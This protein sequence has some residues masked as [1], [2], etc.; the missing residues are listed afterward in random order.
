MELRTQPGPILCLLCSIS[1]HFLSENVNFQSNQTFYHPEQSDQVD[2]IL[3]DEIIKC[4][5]EIGVGH[6]FFYLEFAFAFANEVVGPEYVCLFSLTK[7]KIE[8]ID[9]AFIDTVAFL[10]ARTIFRTFHAVWLDL[11]LNFLIFKVCINFV[12]HFLLL[13]LLPTSVQLLI[14]IDDNFRHLLIQNVFACT[15]KHFSDTHLSNM[16]YLGHACNETQISH[17]DSKFMHHL[18]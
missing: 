2:I 5:V 12:H 18:C 10:A 14:F 6:C 15:P 4:A 13:Q 3:I 8:Y 9:Y 16:R 17:V 11:L 1:M 7:N